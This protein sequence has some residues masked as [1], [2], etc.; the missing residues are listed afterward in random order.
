MIEMLWFTA[1]WCVP[2]QKM[3]PLIAELQ[4][5]GR[6]ITK[7]DVETNKALADQFGVQAMPTFIITQD[8][9]PVRRVIGAREKWALEAEFR[10]AE[11]NAR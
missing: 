2:C 10:M 7:I 1:E 11:D 3:S 6:S 8:G 9:V 4:A 5:E